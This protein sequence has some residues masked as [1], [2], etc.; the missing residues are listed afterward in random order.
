MDHMTGGGDD[1]SNN[2]DFGESNGING[3]HTMQEKLEHFAAIK[4]G[5]LDVTLSPTGKPNSESI[6]SKKRSFIKPLLY[7]KNRA[8][9]DK[10][11]TV[12]GA[13]S[14]LSSSASGSYPVGHCAAC[15]SVCCYWA[16]LRSSSPGDW[17]TYATGGSRAAA[18]Y[19]RGGQ[20]CMLM[21]LLAE[22]E[23]NQRSGQ[24]CMQ[25]P[26]IARMLAHASLSAMV[27]R[28]MDLLR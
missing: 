4:I 10:V 14:L 21:L 20:R 19:Q 18:T 8:Q 13:D 6:L 11:F 23:A 17:W 16:A 15:G 26:L 7:A 2:N 25:M 22:A 9:N 1:T 28:R 5:S 3:G 27:H 12:F 24:R